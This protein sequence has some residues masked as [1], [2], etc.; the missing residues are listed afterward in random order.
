[1]TDNGQRLLHQV[2]AR[3]PDLVDQ[4][5]SLLGRR[6]NAG[7][8]MSSGFTAGREQGHRRDVLDHS[9]VR[10]GVDAALEHRQPQGEQFPSLMTPSPAGTDTPDNAASIGLMALEQ[11]RRLVGSVR[12]VTPQLRVLLSGPDAR[13]YITPIGTTVTGAL[14]RSAKRRGHAASM[15]EATIGDPS[16]TSRPSGEH[17]RRSRRP[18][19]RPDEQHR[20]R[21]TALRP[22]AQRRLQNAGRPQAAHH[23]YGETKGPRGV[24]GGP[25]ARTATGHRGAAG[26]ARPGRPQ[27]APGTA[28]EG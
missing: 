27:A 2:V 8:T 17:A 12:V 11:P 21:G 13:R 10:D 1:M 23:R 7:L 25:E 16:P 3:P 14:C 20:A 18:P 15:A 6:A 19:P 28:G 9:P 5:E 22:R 26:H 4:A 24:S